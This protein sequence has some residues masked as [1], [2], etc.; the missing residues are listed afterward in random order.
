MGWIQRAAGGTQA[1]GEG[2]G[3]PWTR[4]CQVALSPGTSRWGWGASFQECFSKQTFLWWTK[5]CW[6]GRLLET[7][8]AASSSF[9]KSIYLSNQGLGRR[10]SQRYLTLALLRLLPGLPSL[11]PNRRTK[12]RTSDR[13]AIRARG[14]HRLSSAYYSSR[15][16]LQPGPKWIKPGP[17]GPYTPAWRDR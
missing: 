14:A 10:Q 2:K 11:P 9:Q 7:S 15:P 6:R 4:R 5:R 16:R 13:T 3:G 8:T 12:P 1:G 17:H